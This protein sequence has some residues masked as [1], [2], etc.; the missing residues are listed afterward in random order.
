MA[1]KA[2]GRNRRPPK[3][4]LHYQSGSRGQEVGWAIKHKGPP[5]K[6]HCFQQGSI[7]RGPTLFSKST[8]SSGTKGSK[9]EQIV[10]ILHS[11]HSTA[12]VVPATQ[13]KELRNVITNN[14]KAF[15]NLAYTAQKARSAA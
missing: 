10:N 7:Q 8:T 13:D 11:N 9:D 6:S 14:G 4:T 1:E 5:T 2:C 15:L 3:T 12:Q